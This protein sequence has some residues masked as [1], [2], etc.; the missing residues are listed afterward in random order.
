MAMMSPYQAFPLNKFTFEG[1]AT[2]F[3]MTTIRY[4][5]VHF[6]E[7]GDLSYTS[8]NDGTQYQFTGFIVGDDVVVSGDAATVTT[9]GKVRIS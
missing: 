7:D 1:V 4:N 2:D 5:L 9:T 8:A 6:I 3:D